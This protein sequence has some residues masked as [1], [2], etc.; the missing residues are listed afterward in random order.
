MR[1]WRRGGG[2]EKKM[3]TFRGLGSRLP[4]L[5]TGP[6]GWVGRSGRQARSGVDKKV[7]VGHKAG[8]ADRKV[9]SLDEAGRMVGA[10]FEKRDGKGGG[11]ASGSSLEPGV[12]IALPGPV[13]DRPYGRLRLV[14]S[15][16]VRRCWMGR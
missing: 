15:L 11:G 3:L 7:W 1:G 2:A 5:P 10:L 13:S 6:P 16:A 14:C 8:P 12:W 9:G 4:L